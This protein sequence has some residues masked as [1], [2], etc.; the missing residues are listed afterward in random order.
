VSEQQLGLDLGGSD[1]GSPLALRATKAGFESPAPSFGAC[2]WCHRPVYRPAHD[3]CG[4]MCDRRR[5]FSEALCGLSTLEG[6][7][8]YP[9]AL[10]AAWG[11]LEALCEDVDGGGD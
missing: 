7:H 1:S 8:P 4:Q 5:A 9:E 11:R 3:T 6:G 10:E 2:V